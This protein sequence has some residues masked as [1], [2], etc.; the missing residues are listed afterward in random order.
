MDYKTGKQPE[1]RFKEEALLPIRLYAA[2]LSTRSGVTVSKVRLLY[3]SPAHQGVI[4]ELVSTRSIAKTKRQFASVWSDVKTA[5]RTGRFES[6]TSP[7]CDYC[8]AQPICP[9]W[10]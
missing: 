7:L 3:I 9:A 4:E 5:A 8:D 10:T 2:A 1:A 6:R